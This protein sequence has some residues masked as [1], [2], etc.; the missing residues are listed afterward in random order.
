MVS[1]GPV[2]DIPYPPKTSIPRSIA[3]RASPADIA[4]PPM[5]TF[6]P[7]RSI[8][9]ATGAPSSMCRI[10]GTQCENVTR[11]RSMSRSSF[12]GS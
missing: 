7:L 6:Q 10:V 2:S 3:A 12:S 8:S 9:P 4:E 11:S 5:T 1:T